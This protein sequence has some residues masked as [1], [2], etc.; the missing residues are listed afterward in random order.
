M[1]F[2]ELELLAA[3]ARRER[4]EVAVVLGLGFVGTAVAASLSEVTQGA[5]FLVIGVELDTPEG[6]RKAEALDAGRAPFA[7]QDPAVAAALSAAARE[8]RRL[9]ATTDPAVVALADVVLVCLNVDLARESGQTER[10]EVKLEGC[11]RALEQVGERLRPGAL[12]VVEST[13]PVGASDRVLYPALCAGAARAG[14]DVERDPPLYA[15]CYERVTPGPNYLDS[16]HRTPRS[17]A[18]IDRRSTERMR[19]FLQRVMDL[20]RHPAWEHRSTRAA[21]LAKL[22]ENAYRA[23]NIAFVD[24]WARVAERVGVDLFDVVRSIRVRKGTHDNLMLPGLGVG[25][26]CL[27]KDS[28]LAAWGAESLLGVSAE[29]PFS[30]RAILVNEAMPLRALRAAEDHFGGHLGGL[31]A[32]LFGV[33]Y[34]AGVEDTRSSPSETLARALLARGVRVRAHDPLCREWPELPELPLCASPEE[35]LSGASLA[36]VALPD[37]AYAARLAPLFARALPAGGLLVDPWNAAAPAC[38][39]ELAA[40]GVATFVYGRGD[41]PPVRTEAS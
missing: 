38:A 5:G 2:A 34:R 30:R 14:R 39:A 40:R 22:L 23:T 12:V 7:A 41:L 8:P 31:S 26:Y 24:E 16:V 4:R 18:G 27:T 35:A 36:V 19:A 33:T 13:L 21:E 28:L 9:A 25:G 15:Y 6:R 29:L 1:K 20:E 32:A 11:R 3:R 37:E 17:F 10:L